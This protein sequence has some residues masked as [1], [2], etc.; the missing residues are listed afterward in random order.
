MVVGHVSSHVQA[1][2]DS[3]IQDMGNTTQVVPRRQL[4]AP[5]MAWA[6]QSL[7]SLSHFWCLLWQKQDVGFETACPAGGFSGTLTFVPTQ[8]P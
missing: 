5:T 1:A 4:L 6:V 8:Q 7:I 3:P 2:G